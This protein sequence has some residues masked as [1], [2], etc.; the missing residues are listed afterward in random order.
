MRLSGPHRLHTTIASLV[1]DNANATIVEYPRGISC[2]LD[3]P[4]RAYAA[5]THWPDAT[6]LH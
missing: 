1:N 5:R 2:V 3:P 6:A 4:A